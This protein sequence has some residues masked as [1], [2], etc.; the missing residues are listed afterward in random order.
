MRILI[1]EDNA[2]S[3][4]MLEATLGS[5]GHEIQSATDGLEA[6]EALKAETPPDAVILDWIMPGLDGLDVCRLAKDSVRGLEV[7]LIMLTSLGSRRH[8]EMA[9]EA[10]VDDYLTKPLDPDELKM[11]LKAAE[12]IVRLQS[13]LREARQELET[14]RRQLQGPVELLESEAGELPDVEGQARAV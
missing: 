11:R 14:L 8:I 2:V 13:E 7:Y 1:V 9:R 3:R 5:W 6:W 10:G 12:R 4:R